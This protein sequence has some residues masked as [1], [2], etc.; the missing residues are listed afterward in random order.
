MYV[1]DTDPLLRN[2]MDPVTPCE[3]AAARCVV[4]GVETAVQNARAASATI[5]GPE[6][7]SSFGPAVVRDA[8]QSQKEMSTR[9]Q[10]PAIAA[11]SVQHQADLVAAPEIVPLNVSPEEYGSCAV[12]GSPALMPRPLTGSM[13]IWGDAGS[14]PS[15]PGW[16][17][18]A[19]WGTAKT[20]GF[21][22]LA[23]LG[24][25]AMA[26]SNGQR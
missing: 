3:A 4:Q 11:Q 19:S 16:E 23:A 24:L 26:R 25:W 10:L 8:A 20:L 12:K 22:A 17:R 7:F 18:P 15:G 9:N 6:S 13:T 14:V 5:A 21:L 1:R 2:S